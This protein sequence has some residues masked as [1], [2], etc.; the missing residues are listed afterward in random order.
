LLFLLARD[1]LAKGALS[2]WCKSR[3]EGRGR[4]YE[5]AKSTCTACRR[6]C[7]LPIFPTPSTS[8]SEVLHVA[9]S[10]GAEPFIFTTSTL[11]GTVEAGWSLYV[12]VGVPPSADDS[13]WLLFQRV[14]S[15]AA[16]RERRHASVT[17]PLTVQPPTFTSDESPRA[18]LAR[19]FHR[20]HLVT[21]SD[22]HA[23]P[24]RHTILPSAYPLS[25]L[26]P[27]L[28][29]YANTLHASRGHVRFYISRA[30]RLACC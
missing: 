16:S 28:R 25:L 22:A 6:G 2:A 23:L 4:A 17:V 19:T 7:T 12:S 5:I 18:D 24:A 26:L 20:T 15:C 14:E 30:R 1:A 9:F 10:W 29:T 27:A 3:S 21:C 8:A 11:P 13:S